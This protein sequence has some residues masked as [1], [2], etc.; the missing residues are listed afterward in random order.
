MAYEKFVDETLEYDL[1]SY[2]G[3]KLFFRGPKRDLNEDYIAFLGGTETFGKFLTDPFPALVEQVLQIPCVNLGWSNA[4]VDVF[5]NDP[6]V[7]QIA[8]RARAVVLQ[9][10]CAQN[11]SNRFYSVHPRR[12][13]RFLGPSQ[14]MR[15]MFPEVD[16][17]EFHFTRHLLTH[18]QH[19][20]PDRFA[21]LRRELQTIWV[22]RMRLL[23]KKI[24][25]QV[26]LLWFSKRRPGE[27]SG[28]PDLALDPAFIT[29][30][31]IQSIRSSMAECLEVCASSGAQEAGLTG[32][33]YSPVEENAA[34]ELLGPKAHEE[35]ALAL[36]HALKALV[37]KQKGPSG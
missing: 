19:V 37:Q 23:I 31:M 20:A 29:R 17:T 36:N 7:L 15:R 30:Q 12:N 4:G 1:C 28:A 34:S 13:D 26:L 22:S 9:L 32:M 25:R 35:A 5:L 18:L 8:R 6:G 3:S 33:V 14:L 27:E 24:D 11:M 21:T 2:T 10:P 16:F